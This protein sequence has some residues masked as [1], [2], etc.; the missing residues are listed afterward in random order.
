MVRAL[1]AGMSIEQ[2]WQSTWR[3]FQLYIIAHEREQL[4]NWQRTRSIA[5][6]LYLANSGDKLKKTIDQFWHLPGDKK[7]EEKDNFATEEQI[8]ETINRMTNGR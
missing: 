1:Q 8:L 5:Y 4:T 3:D 6:M 7:I 2:F